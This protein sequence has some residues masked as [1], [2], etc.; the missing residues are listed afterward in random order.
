[1]TKILIVGASGFIGNYLFDYLTKNLSDDF[2]IKGTYYSNQTESG[3]VRLDITNSLQIDKCLLK[4]KP[5]ILLILAGSKNVKKCEEDYSFAYKM[6]TKSTEFII[7]SIKK[8]HLGTKVIFFSTD[9]V[10]DG[11]KGSYTTKDDTNPTTNYGRTK[12]LAEKIVSGSGIDFKIVRTS[13]V[14]GKNGPFF[15]WLLNEIRSKKMVSLFD[16]VFFSPTPI[17]LLSEMIYTLIRDYD[18][19]NYKLLHIAGNRR[20]SRYDFALIINEIVGNTDTLIVA[21]SADLNQSLFSKDLSLE[22]SDFTKIHQKRTIEDYL[23][24]EINYD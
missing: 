1:M 11:K 20:L 17:G 24:D 7:D 3:F 18:T 21:D 22:Q 23:R 5:D 6:N 16:N 8:H 14:M 2:I 9:Y 4:E 15:E 10:F 13:A 12:L 19:I